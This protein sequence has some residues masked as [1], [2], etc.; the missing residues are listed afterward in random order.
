MIDFQDIH[1]GIHIEHIAKVKNVSVLRASLYFKCSPHDILEMYKKKSLDSS[2]L[3]KW[4]K[5]LNYNFFMIYHSH[6][7][8]FASSASRAKLD[9][10]EIKKSYPEYVLKRI[11]ICRSH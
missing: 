6:L 7:Q 3:L 10:K 11:Y 5:L 9:E 4:C 1:I 2:L 8:I